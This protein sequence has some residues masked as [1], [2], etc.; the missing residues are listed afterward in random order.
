V[1][2]GDTLYAAANAVGLTGAYTTLPG[3]NYYQ[4]NNPPTNFQLDAAN[5]G[6]NYVS[7]HSWPSS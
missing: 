2:K 1:A 5:V 7:P 6:Y 4:G 3:L